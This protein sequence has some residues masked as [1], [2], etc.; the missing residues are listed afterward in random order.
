[1]GEKNVFVCKPDVVGERIEIRMYGSK[2]K[3]ELCEVEVKGIPGEIY[4]SYYFCLTNKQ[5]VK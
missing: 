4:F 1:M 3:L 2:V 5:L